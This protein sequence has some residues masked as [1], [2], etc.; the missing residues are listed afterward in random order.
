[1]GNDL[2]HNRA[3]LHTRTTSRAQVLDN[4]PGLFLDFYLE[5]SRFALHRFQIRV[6][7]EFD[8]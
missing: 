3:V 8:V 5:I 6:G 2:L 7:D 1:L 4:T